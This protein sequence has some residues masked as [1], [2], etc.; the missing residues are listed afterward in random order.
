MGLAQ[1]NAPIEEQR[2]IRL[3]RSFG[4]GERSSMGQTVAV[5]YDKGIE[6]ITGI[7]PIVHQDVGSLLIIPFLAQVIGIIHFTVGARLIAPLG[8]AW[9]APINSLVPQVLQVICVGALGGTS[10]GSHA[11]G[12]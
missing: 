9:E 6:S 8:G 4:Y 10:H 5:A 12:G 11:S 3:A 1:S 2:I 7:E